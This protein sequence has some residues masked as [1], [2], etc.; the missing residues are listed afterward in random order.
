MLMQQVVDSRV[1]NRREYPRVPF[2]ES[3]EYKVCRRE[4]VSSVR[5]GRVTNISQGGL[6]IEVEHVLPISSILLVDIN[7]A[8]LER[9]INLNDEVCMVGKAVLTKVVNLSRRKDDGLF[10][11]GVSFIHPWERQRADVQAALALLLC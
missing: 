1:C 5:E 9:C 6:R 8:L 11:A 4:L 10:V 2:L 7:Y 3:I